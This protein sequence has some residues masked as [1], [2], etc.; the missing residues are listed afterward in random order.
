MDTSTF[1]VAAALTVI[2]HMAVAVFAIT[3]ALVASRRQMD[4]VGFAI[5][6]TATGI[7]GGSVRD[8]LLGQWPVFW[9]GQTSYLLTCIAVATVTFFTAHLLDS[10]YRAILWLDALGL[11]L[12]GVLGAERALA[13]GA[14]PVVAVLMG[15]ISATFGGIIRDILSAERPLILSPEIY[16]TAALIGAAVYVGAL[17][18]GLP[19]AWATGIGMAAGFA[20]RAGGLALGWR[21]P[22]YKPRPPRERP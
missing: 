13:A 10:R 5:L 16:M 9:I 15:V 1:D 17:A 21:L 12:F 7:G 8:V 14:N 20:T 22:V 19:P 4:I 18:A 2:D 11:A 3:G 6:G